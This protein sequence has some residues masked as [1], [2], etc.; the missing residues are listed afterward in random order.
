M[1]E[2]QDLSLRE[3]ADLSGTSYAY[4]SLVER[5]ER[6]PTDRWLRMV[7]DALARHMLG[8]SA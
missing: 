4:L 8:V 7:T 3:L 2:A 6:T 1:R 5:D